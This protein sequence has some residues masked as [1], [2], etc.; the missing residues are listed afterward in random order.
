MIK[1]L[2]KNFKKKLWILN[3]TFK[4][5]FYDLIDFKKL[6]TWMLLPEK[7]KFLSKFTRIPK[8]SRK[9]RLN[10]WLINNFLFSNCR[11]QKKVK[12]FNKLW[13]YH[14]YIIILY[15]IKWII[16]KWKLLK[17]K[18][19]RKKLTKWKFKSFTKMKVK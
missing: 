3:F 4:V 11:R 16:A 13:W 6:A 9:T 7:F 18:K 5:W 15:L 10:N 1:I 2:S 8:N 17:H 12:I 14:S 19:W